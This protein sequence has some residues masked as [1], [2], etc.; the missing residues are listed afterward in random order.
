MKTKLVLAFSLVVIGL[1]C[2]QS[3]VSIADEPGA[4]YYWQYYSPCTCD[5]GTPGHW[6][7]CEKNGN[8]MESC[9]PK[10]H[11]KDCQNDQT[12]EFCE[13]PSE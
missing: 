13:S 12:G 8:T 4:S 9:S 6:Y 11:I 10:G 5:N 2:I 7:K 3:R 1:L